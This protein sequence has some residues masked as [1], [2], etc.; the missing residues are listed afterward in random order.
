MLEH[1]QHPVPSDD[2]Y[3]FVGKQE[4]P[5]K[6][7]NSFLG[8]EKKFFIGC[9][10]QWGKYAFN[11][12]PFIINGKEFFTDAQISVKKMLPSLEGEEWKGVRT[13]ISP[14]FTSGK[15][16][17]MMDYFNS[18]AK[19]WVASLTRK[20]NASADGS[21]SIA[22]LKSVNQYT[23]DVIAS[24]VFGFQAGTIKDP[25]SQF[26]K[27]ASRVSDLTR[28][29]LI[30]FVITIQFPKIVSMLKMKIIDGEALAFFERI[31]DQGLKARMSGS[32]TKR[33]DFL[34]LLVE[35]KKGELKAEGKDELNSFEKEAQ[36]QG[37]ETGE[38]KQWLTKQIMN[39]HQD[40]QD[41]LRNEV[42][43]I[44][45]EDGSLDYDELNTL[46]YLD[47][48][49]C[50]VIRKYP[51]AG[52]LDR[53]CT[54]DYKE[55]E[56]GLSIPKDSIVIIPVNAIHNDPQYYDN[57]DK[58][59]PEHFSPD[60][61]AQRNTYAYLPF[62]S[63][64]RNCIGMRFALTETKASVAHLVNSFRIEPTKK[65]P[66]PMTGYYAGFALHPPKGY[67][68]IFWVAK[69]LKLDFIDLEAFVFFERILDQ[70]LKSRIGDTARR[71]DFF[72]IW[73]MQKG[74]V[75]GN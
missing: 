1:F 52:R 32:T 26:A 47:M 50:E 29:Q 68:C 55:N 48:V 44:V 53:K 28:W 64:P 4:F 67:I 54:R 46:V 17:R 24:A 70:G 30:K 66:I 73:W 9:R 13:A 59:D 18:V 69:E 60:K 41:K 15:I 31:L 23:L 11:T 62:G 63:G 51:M 19:E 20:A 65:T 2:K 75:E 14:T 6:T 49:I 36:I 35:A 57:P 37:A 8:G 22:A 42:S 40:V 58:F 61:K 39:M 56:S 21:V 16:R 3:K 5:F 27:M 10:K 74:G 45:K 38:K 7:G 43:K 34:Q 33:N 71:N 12:T 25:K 72:N